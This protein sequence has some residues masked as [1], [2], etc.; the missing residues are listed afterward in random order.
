MKLMK[1]ENIA[2]I[3]AIEASGGEQIGLSI[4]RAIALK[5]MVLL[6][7]EPFSNL[8]AHLRANLFDHIRKLRDEEGMTI[9]I[10]S[11]DGQDVLGLPQILFIL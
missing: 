5:P 3:K 4:A 8:D 9:I 1:L 7:D 2:D 10:V 11:H 6:L